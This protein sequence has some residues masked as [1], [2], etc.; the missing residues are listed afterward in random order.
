[1]FSV[2]SS[3]CEQTPSLF[4]FKGESEAYEVVRAKELE[5][6]LERSKLLVDIH[7]TIDKNCEGG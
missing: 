3:E 2:Y 4:D 1:M 5:P 7:Q 6:M